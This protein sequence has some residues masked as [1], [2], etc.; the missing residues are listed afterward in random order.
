MRRITLL[1]GASLMLAVAAAF[2]MNTKDEMVHRR[3]KED[4]VPF[5]RWEYQLNRLADPRTGKVPENMYMRELAY[6][7]NLPKAMNRRDTFSVNFESIGPYNVGGRT[8]AFDIDWNNPNVYL[9]GGVSG[10]MWRSIDAGANWVKVTDADAHQAVSCI[11][12]DRRPGKSNIWYYGSGETVGNSASK[13]FSAFYRGS[14]MFKSTD[15]GETWLHLQITASL[16]NKD[17]RWDAV[18]AIE[19]DPVRLDSDIVYAA[20]QNGIQRSND[21]GESW[22]PVLAA[23][24]TTDFTD[25]TITSSGVLYAS[26]SSNGGSNRGIWRSEDG[27]DWVDITANQFPI[28]HERTI[29]Q[30]AP[31]NENV[32]YFFSHTPGAGSGGVSLWKYEY[33]DGEGTGSGGNWTNLSSGLASADFSVFGGY[34]QVMNV[35]PDDENM[36]FLGG[37]NLYRSTNGFTDTFQITRIGGYSIDGDTNYTYFRGQG[38]HYPDQQN[39][40][41]HPNDPDFLISTTD[42]GV[43]LAT[44]C[45]LDTMQWQSL[46]NG[47]V[48]SQFYAIGI[49]QVTEG[50]EVVI[51]GLQDR[52]TFWTNEAD[53]EVMWTH[54]R[55]ADGAYC[56]IEDGGGRYYI[57]TQYANI[58]R[59]SIDENGERSNR[60]N[61][62]PKQLGSGSGQGWLFVHPFTLDRNDNNIMYLPNRGN[63]WRNDNITATDSVP[64]FSA[65]RNICSVPGNITAISSSE[66]DLGVVYFGTN[67]GRIYRLN[68]A[69]EGFNLTPTSLNDSIGASGYTSNIAIDPNNSDRA[70]AVFSNYNTISMYYTEDGGMDWE[71]IEGNLRGT[72]DDGIPEILYYI[73]DGPSVRWAEIVPIPNG[74]LYF[75]GTSVGLFA[76]EELNGDS[77]VWVQQAPNSIGNVVVDMIQY[78]T[79]DGFMAIGTHGNGIYTGT[80]NYIETP[81]GLER[82]TYPNEALRWTVYP[83]PANDVLRVKFEMETEQDVQLHI[84]DQ[85]ARLVKQLHFYPNKGETIVEMDVSSLSKGIYFAKL[86]CN[87]IATSKKVVLTR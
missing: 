31:S 13:S 17:S 10:G 82:I 34:C 79:S 8:R 83:N 18:F 76:T 39:L 67:G 36:I 25:V 4:V 33:I 63:L 66:A 65:W 49:D 70:I 52:G 15:N 11:V 56:E 29:I 22:K 85:Q 48:S 69:Q 62:M 77:T 32:V 16:P 1:I 81:E 71:P 78:R 51:G 19:T 80:I 23:Q 44:D 73:G 40:Y 64:L 55:G 24:T 6:A 58:Q 28:N 84:Y 7:A 20:I 38:I 61:I 72:T 87:G 26:I 21:G 60:E 46:N 3:V 74:N 53:P 43:H 45:T 42:G 86:S 68:N 2:L 35:K 14:G 9:A 37:T 75:V 5:G 30:Y 59:L 12:Q 57:S 50:S 41:F 54:V 27:I 47:Y